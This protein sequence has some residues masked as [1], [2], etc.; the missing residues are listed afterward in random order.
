VKFIKGILG[1]EQVEQHL[2]DNRQI[3]ATIQTQFADIQEMLAVSLS[4]FANSSADAIADRV[5][6]SVSGD[7]PSSLADLQQQMA[8][9]QQQLVVL[10]K[11][12]IER[13]LPPTSKIVQLLLS[14]LYA[15]RL[16]NGPPYYRFEDIEF[17]AFSENGEDGILLYIFSMIGMTNKKCVEMCC[18]NGIECNTANWLINHGWDGL[19]FDGDEAN[20]VAGREF[21]SQCP[22]TYFRPP[23]LVSAWI[24]TDKV[25]SLIEENGYGGPLDLFSL[26]MDGVDYWI[27]KAINCIQPRVV[28]LEFNA[29]WGPSRAVTVAY[30]PDFR[31]D[32]SRLRINR[33]NCGAS[34]SAFCNLAREKGYRLVGLQRGGWNAF[35]LRNGVGDQIFPEIPPSQAFAEN[36]SLMDWSTSWIPLG[37]DPGAC[38]WLEV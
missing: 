31:V 20:I 23:T 28:V 14:N 15:Q 22:H 24:D 13:Q 26:D 8:G 4:Q 34:L 27:W 32:Q 29:Y 1:L 11:A 37:I 6:K 33:M 35:F 25:N 17:R 2:L 9:I 5:T 7:T 21:Y 30:K 36:R 10:D 12:N 19:L 18:G 16:Q 38:E 3:L